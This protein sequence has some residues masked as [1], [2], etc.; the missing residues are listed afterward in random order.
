MSDSETRD[1]ATSDAATSDSVTTHAASDEGQ[2]RLQV[3]AVDAVVA[4]VVEREVSWVG[5]S[6]DQAQRLGGALINQ[7]RAA[8]K[9]NQSPTE[10]EP[11][12]EA[13]PEPKVESEPEAEPETTNETPSS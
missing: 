5:L 12:A 13:E 8:R 1:A 2:L 10:P 11:N 9:Q 7:A 6:P 3:V 4:L